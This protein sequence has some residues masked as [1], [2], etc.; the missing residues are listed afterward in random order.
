MGHKGSCMCGAVT[1]EATAPVE[2]AGAC[3]C[4]MCRKWTGGVFVAFRLPSD[5]LKID[6]ADNL[7]VFSSSPWA[8][9]TSCKICGSSLY[10]RVT[11]EGPNQGEYYVGL[12]TLD[13]PSGIQ[14]TGELFIDLKP[15]GYAFAGE[16]RHQM[17]EAEVMAMFAQPEGS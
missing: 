1:Y 8:E 17:T 4:K 3:H 11:A 7:N 6:G 13:D 12:G 15:D 10:Y 2:E 14:L 9:R 5:G 16:G